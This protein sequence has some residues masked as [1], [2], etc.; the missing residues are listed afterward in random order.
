MGDEDLSAIR[1]DVL[2]LKRSVFGFVD[3]DSNAFVPG[4]MQLAADTAREL[5]QIKYVL[6]AGVALAIGSRPDLWTVVEKVWPK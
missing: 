5:R 4:V 6:I 1:T 2:Q 3:P